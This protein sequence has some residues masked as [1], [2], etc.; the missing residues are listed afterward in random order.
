[1]R[2]KKRGGANFTPQLI[3]YNGQGKFR[4]WCQKVLPLVYDDSMSYYELL[5]KVVDYLNH[6]ISDIDSAET[7]VD[8][9]LNAYNQLQGYVNSYFDSLDVQAAIDTKL[10]E[11]VESGEFEEI[12]NDSVIETT[13]VTTER[14]LDDHLELT[15]LDPPIVLLDGTLSISG[16]VAE[17]ANTGASVQQLSDCIALRYD[18]TKVYKKGEYCT[19]LHDSFPW[20]GYTGPIGNLQPVRLMVYKCNV[21][22]GQAEAW[23]PLH[24]DRVIALEELVA[25]KEYVDSIS[26]LS[27]D[28]KTALLNCFEHV[29][30]IDVHGQDYYDDLYDALYPSAELLYIDAVLTQGSTVVYPDTSLDDLRSMLTVT[31]YY[32]DNTSEIVTNYTLSGNLSVGNSDVTVTYNGKTDVVT[33][34]VT[35]RPELDSI[36]A[37]FNQGQTV[38][39]DTDSLDVLRPMLTVTANYS[40][41]TTETITEYTLSGTLTVGTST[42]T[43][44]YGGKTATFDVTVTANPYTWKYEASSG[45]LLSARTDLGTFSFNGGV[46]TLNNNLLNVSVTGAGKYCIFSPTINTCPNGGAIEVKIR[47]NHTPQDPSNSPTGFRL[48]ISNGTGG[49][50]LFVYNDSIASYEGTT[51]INN[52]ASITTNV[53]HTVKVELL[54]GSSK[55]YID[56]TIVRQTNTLSTQYATRNG[57]YFQSAGTTNGY[58]DV[59]IEWIGFT[60]YN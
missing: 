39:Y 2:D 53:W 24:W 38:V 29:A 33:V 10:D 22:M 60:K 43:V 23:N 16:G 20:G 13:K 17:A 6:C 50:Q 4:F 56:N 7:N 48:Q 26:G 19:N 9:L 55:L 59:D 27:D 35:A 30:W 32:D 15:S 36:T 8:R 46:E 34:V 37:V 41:S 42:V 57:L 44:S 3:G 31:A 58:L 51:P 47:F 52:I 12:V 45:V 49:T 25:L 54:A 40:D 11:M 5:N 21:D 14:W 1:M 18:S 28:V